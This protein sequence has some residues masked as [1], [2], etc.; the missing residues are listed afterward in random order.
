M[1]LIPISTHTQHRNHLP[2][3]HILLWIT[4][5]RVPAQF[6]FRIGEVRLV[7]WASPSIDN[8]F[9]NNNHIYNYNDDNESDNSPPTSP[10]PNSNQTYQRV[11]LSGRI[12]PSLPISPSTQ[13]TASP[14][15]PSHSPYNSDVDIDVVEPADNDDFN[16]GSNTQGERSGARTVEIE[17]IS[18]IEEDDADKGEQP[19]LGYLD[20]ALSYLATERER[21]A[22]QR[23]AGVVFGKSPTYESAWRHVIGAYFIF[24]SPLHF[25]IPM[26]IYAYRTPQETPPKT[27]Q[28]PPT[29]TPISTRPHNNQNYT[30]HAPTRARH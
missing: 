5:L 1:P 17:D 13:S 7:R 10:P 24:Y 21:F 6:P 12:D 9:S 18:D 27:H 16:L 4:R 30:P 22:A 19:S 28:R 14:P 15:S 26:Y 29:Q 8:H 23:E 2:L 20:K 11:P 25:S 3:P